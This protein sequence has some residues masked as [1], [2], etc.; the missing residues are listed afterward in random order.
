MKLSESE[1]LFKHPTKEL[2]N[3]SSF[4]RW[5]YY[6]LIGM[7]RPPLLEMVMTFLVCILV[8]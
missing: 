3:P 2:E 8:E 1:E 6:A 4:R 7:S 5:K